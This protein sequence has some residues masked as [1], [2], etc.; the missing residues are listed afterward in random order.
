M[1][2][3]NQRHWALHQ[4]DMMK[5]LSLF[6]LVVAAALALMVFVGVGTAS[7]EA[8]LCKDTAG[9]ECY[10][11]GTNFVA[12]TIQL[13]DTPNPAG[14]THAAWTTNAFGTL[15][16]NGTLSGNIGTATTP[17]INAT[18]TWEKCTNNVIVHTVTN[19]TLGIHHD[20]EHNGTVT[21]KN[22]V[23]TF[24]VSGITCYYGGDLTGTLTASSTTPVIHFTQATAAIDTAAHNSSAFCPSTTTF[25][26]TYTVTKPSS[27]YVR[28]GV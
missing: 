22:Y 5:Y 17:S 4:G 11:V 7:A 28:T 18:A 24:N 6:G 10:G 12:H 2:V 1:H 13:T 21:L 27:L 9:N 8:T 3:R 20:A 23:K 19:G 26:A 16:C 25:H 14:N 15:E